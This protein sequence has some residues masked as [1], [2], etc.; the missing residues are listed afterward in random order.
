MAKTKQTVTEEKPLSVLRAP[1]QLA[2]RYLG[3]RVQARLPYF[4]DLG[5]S[6]QK[7]GIKI[8]LQSYVSMLFLLPGGSFFAAL[9][10]TGVI[11]IAAGTP[12]V[13]A[14]LFA[15]GLALLSGT[16]VFAILYGFPWLLA[17]S[18]RRR[19]ELEL[20]YVSSHMTILAAAG[21]PPTRMFKLLEDSRTTPQV[22]SEANEI[23]RDVEVLGDD[24]MTAL[25]KERERS[26]SVIFAEVL[27]GLVATIRSGGNIKSYLMDTTRLMMD[28]KR[29]AAKQL[30]ESLATFAEIYV[31]LMVVFP[32]LVIVMFSVMALLGG[33][34]GGFSVTDLM[35]LV[36]YLIIPLCGF[37]VMVMLDTMLVED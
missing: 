14:L 2:F 35:A 37:A 36:T 9:T 24:I 4:R 19:M 27:E 15:F 32:L 33:V 12:L 7:A 29:L 18:R 23:I 26:P 25:E 17:T 3:A 8:G 20:P 28:L 22:A 34:L 13:T 10:I 6:M 16:G 1:W 30:I 11:A 31:T 5:F 21:I